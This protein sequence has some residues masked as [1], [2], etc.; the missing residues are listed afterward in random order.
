MEALDRLRECLE[1]REARALLEGARVVRTAGGG[2]RLLVRDA[3]ARRRLESRHLAE[4]VQ[5][6]GGPIEVAARAA[7][8]GAAAPPDLSG[9]RGPAGIFALRMVRAFVEGKT[10]AA[11]LVVLHG[12]ETAGRKLLIDWAEARGG[13]QIFR[14]DFARMRLARSRGLV[15]R[16]PLVVGNGV[17]IL[18][19]RDAGQ[20]T[21]C[22]LIEAVLGRG[23]RLLLGLDTHPARCEGLR[24]NLRSRLLGGV[25]APVIGT[26]PRP[27]APAERLEEAK[28]SAARIFG[29]EK[30]LLESGCR[31]R[32]VVEARRV[33]I[34]AARMQGWDEQE[35]AGA[36][37]LR[38]PRSVREACR[39][40]RL[41][42]AR[43]ETFA[44]I[45]KELSRVLPSR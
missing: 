1:S 21:L 4:L 6:F 36:F 14:L 12:P 19:G 7:P 41:Q 11:S 18:A 17:E 28:R 32:R 45:L 15:P 5:A 24:P 31:R 42:Q 16:K 34:A 27:V 10:P 40:A 20:R 35:L 2:M 43:D 38:S 37:G 25:L 9:L 44:G 22:T 29:V 13:R 30:E 3:F 26:E 39:W 33:V 8:R 23:D